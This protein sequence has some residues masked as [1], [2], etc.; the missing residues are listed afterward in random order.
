MAHGARRW[1]RFLFFD[2]CLLFPGLLVAQNLSVIGGTSLQKQLTACIAHVSAKDL[3]KLPG[4][5]HT[6][7]VVILEHEKFMEVK[8]AFGAYRTIFAFS[9]PGANRM[10]LSSNV[11]LD[12]DTAAYCI[13]HELGHLVTRSPYEDNAELAAERIRK[14]ARQVCTMGIEPAPSR[15]SSSQLR[16]ARVTGAE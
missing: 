4:L 5:D 14:R 10:Y 16:S 15:A 8:D 7:T 3:D 2:G 9:I 6:M 12:V 1:F 13:S 11:F